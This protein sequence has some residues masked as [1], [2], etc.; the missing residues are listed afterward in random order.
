MSLDM[1][2]SCNM[3]YTDRDRPEPAGYNTV[4]NKLRMVKI[5]QRDRFKNVCENQFERN[6]LL[7]EMIQRLKGILIILYLK[8]KCG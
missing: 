3:M 7:E 5:R 6:I 2:D 4:C 1:I 8:K